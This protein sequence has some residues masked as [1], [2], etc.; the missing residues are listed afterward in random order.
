MSFVHDRRARRRVAV[1][2]VAGN[3]N[4]SFDVSFVFFRGHYPA[5]RSFFQTVI[6]GKRR[7][8]LALTKLGSPVFEPHL[9][10]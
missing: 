3:S 7:A 5:L 9:Y 10:K 2:V 1:V 8:L 6:F 4:V